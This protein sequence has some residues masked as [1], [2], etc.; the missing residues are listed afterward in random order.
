[1]AGFLV[2]DTETTGLFDFARPADADGQPRLASIAMLFCD[3]AFELQHEW[4]SLVRPDGWEMPH[5][6]EAINGLTTER[7]R[8]EGVDVSVPLA[9][10]AGAI[11]HGRTVVAYNAQYDTKIMR[12]ALRRAGL[13]DLYDHTATLCIME[14]MTDVCALPSARGGYKW[15]KLVQAYAHFFGEQHEGAHGALEDARACHRI[16]QELRRRACAMPIKK[17]A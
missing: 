5:E 1:M 2:I 8:A 15:P 16:A 9:I 6:A 12:G 10:Y 13:P 14:A 4:F 7:L 3:D 17:A 11:E